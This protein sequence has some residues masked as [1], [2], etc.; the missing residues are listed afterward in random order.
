MWKK[1]RNEEMDTNENHYHEVTEYYSNIPATIDGMLNGYSNISDIDIETSEQFLLSLYNR[2]KSSP[3]R[4]RVLDVGAGIGRISKNLLIRYFDKVD[5]LEQSPI[6][7]EEAR[8][9]L[10][11]SKKLDKCFNVGVQHFQIDDPHIKYDV[12]W[13]QWV[14]MFIL[15]EDIKKFIN[16]CK[17]MLNENGIII[18][19]DNVASGVKNEYD[20]EDNSVV[21]S[22]SQ[23]CLLFSKCNLKCVKSEKVTGMPKSLFKV[24]MFALKPNKEK[25]SSVL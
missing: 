15:D 23:F 14:L 21:R 9:S 6:F 7:I 8:H 22:L 11:E 17:Q 4:T 25:D 2:K 13:I 12:I 19:K 5:L 20:E 24:Y 18:I 1:I 3:G 10:K 16:T